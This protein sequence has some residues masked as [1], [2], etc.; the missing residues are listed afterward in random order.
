MIEEGGA[1]IKYNSDGSVQIES[2]PKE[3]RE[4]NGN[5][6][7]MEEAIVGD[8]ALI[9]AWKADKKGNIIFNKSAQNFNSAM[10]MAAKTTIVEVEEIVETGEIP[11]D[12]IH[13]PAVYIDRII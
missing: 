3:T 12:N 6:Y 11:P 8:F 9:K 1:P 13:V 5:N 4:F 2:Q 10:A 7:V